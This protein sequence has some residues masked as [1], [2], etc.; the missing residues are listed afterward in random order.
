MVLK[1]NLFYWNLSLKN[2]EPVI[3]EFYCQD[4]LI[5]EDREF[6]I[7]VERLRELIISYCV[8]CEKDKK[9]AIKISDEIYKIILSMNKVQYT[10]F[11]AFWKVLDISYSIFL[12]LSNKREILEKILN[13]YCQKRRKIYDSLGYSNIT[14]QA[15]YD[16]GSSRKNSV[17]GIKKIKEILNKQMKVEYSRNIKKFEENKI[18]YFLPDKGDKKLFNEFCKKYKICYKFGKGKQSKEPDMVLKIKSHFFI[19]EAKHIKEGGGAQDKQISELISF[20]KNSEKNKCVHY[21]SFIDGIY[22]NYF[23]EDSFNNK[24]SRQKE[25][26]KSHLNN[27]NN[28]FVNTVG[29]KRLFK[30]I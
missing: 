15:L 7:K 17:L 30:D 19:I 20:I 13:E 1:N 3:D 6:L 24:I 14:I 25:D 16:S 4:K 18:S 29:L 2:T 27:K 8:V 9:A 5:V 23:I 22:F 28:F 12:K 10:E 11:V 21:V 26:I